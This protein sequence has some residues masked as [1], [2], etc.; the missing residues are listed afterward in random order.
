[1]LKLIAAELLVSEATYLGEIDIP[2]ADRT[3]EG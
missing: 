3:I 1:V 2:P